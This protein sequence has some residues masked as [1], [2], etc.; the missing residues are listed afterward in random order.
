MLTLID[1]IANKNH[2]QLVKA[3]LPYMQPENQKMLSVMIKMFE[4]QNVLHFYQK[5]NTGIC[6]CSATS[7]PP[8]FLDILT[9]IRN[10]CE[11]EEVALVDQLIQIASTLELYS[12]FMQTAEE[13]GDSPDIAET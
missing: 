8:A 5:S 10:Y 7:E 9:D 4:L 12:V 2:L 6:A 3:L 11:E 13:S 1:K